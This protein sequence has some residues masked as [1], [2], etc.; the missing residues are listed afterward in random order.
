M[1]IDLRKESGPDEIQADVCIVGAGAAGI[2]LALELAGTSLDVCILES[3]DFEYD[4]ATQALAAGDSVGLPYYPLI[5]TRL[6]YFGGTTNHWHGVCRPL[7]EL[8]FQERDS[9]PYS[10]WPIDRAALD[11]YYLRAHEY[12]QLGP[13]NYDPD[14]WTSSDAPLLPLDGDRLVTK[15]M[16]EKA[17][18]FGKEYRKRIG[19]AGNI[20]VILS[21]NATEFE[22]GENGASIVEMRAESLHGKRMSVSARVFVLATGAIENARLLLSSR[23]VHANGI[24]N[25]HD[26][27]GRFFMDHPSVPAMELKLAS[28]DTD[29]SLYTG[30]RRHGLG[31]AGYLAFR[32]ETL[33]QE[34]ML[35]ACAALTVGGVELPIQKSRKGIESA[36]RI[37]NA[38][39]AGKTPP[40]FGS[41]IANLLSDMHWVINY[42]YER[43]FVRSPLSLGVHLQLEQAPNPSSRVMLSDERDSL[44]KQRVTLDWQLGDLERHTIK[45]FGELAGREIGR[46]E[47]GRIRLL[48]PNEAGWWDGMRSSWH[49]MGTTRMH[50]EPTRGVVDADCRVHGIENLYVAGGSIFPTSGFANPTLTIVALAI[51]LADHLRGLHA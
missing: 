33:R 10:G 41:H 39:K 20:R 30:L 26:L 13:Y 16:L 12:C 8:D 4:A 2:S 46:A 11:S 3:G 27:V 51:R 38:F 31:V 36:I 47:L 15:I 5:A 22:P 25:D 21:A 14:Y 6:R 23:K 24:G 32:A 44:G 43:A 29:L 42:S 50:T 37:W 48:E 7:D 34:G 40:N 19:A 45:R 17:V 49:Q 1:F 28:A 35:N 9:I 18:R